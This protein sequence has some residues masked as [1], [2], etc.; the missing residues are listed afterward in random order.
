MGQAVGGFIGL[1]L[2]LLA[3]AGRCQHLYTCFNEHLYGFLIVGALFFPIAI[4]PG[5]RICWA[6]GTDG[7]SIGRTDRQREGTTLF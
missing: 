5:W 7:G 3:F 4:I 1:V 6:G 2:G